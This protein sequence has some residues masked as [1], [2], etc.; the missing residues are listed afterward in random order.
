MNERLRQLGTVVA[1]IQDEALVDDA[2]RVAVR[3]RLLS[4]PLASQPRALWPRRAALGLALAS[5]ALLA[6]LLL[7]K[8]GETEIIA[9]RSG[10]A[11]PSHQVDQWIDAPDTQTL[12]IVFSDGSTVRLSPG[13]RARVRRLTQ[14][15]ASLQLERGEAEVH[16][17][18][19]EDTQWSVQAGPFTVHVIGTRFHVGWEPRREEFALEVFEGSVQ[20]SGPTG[21]RR[22]G[23]GDEEIRISLRPTAPQP[24]PHQVAEPQPPA[25]PTPPA[26]TPGAASP[27]SD[28]TSH[29][30]RWRTPT[31]Q[32]APAPSAA[33]TRP[34]SAPLELKLPPKQPQAEPQKTGAAATPAHTEEHEEEPAQKASEL[35]KPAPVPAWK[36]LADAGEYEQVLSSLSAEQVED[37]IWHGEATDLVNLGTAARRA[38]DARAGYIY[39]VVRSRFAG[40]DAAANAA[41]ILGRMQFHAGVPQSAATWLQTYLRERPNG[42]FS[43][44]AMGRLV[45]SY[46]RAGDAARAQSAARRYLA[47]YPHGPHA[48]LARSVLQ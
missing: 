20:L 41:F 25:L 8:N 22:A 29:R 5:A 24:Q 36:A 9:Y 32:P 35:P 13:A 3:R 37:A 27:R 11:L 17:H 43:R 30:P 21:V 12:P 6:I 4:A 2:R 46:V 16:V 19:E 45:E 23:R 47:R 34:P 10:N 28:A 39:S 26:P 7:Q 48:A 14:T 31:P 44:E 42:R 38:G 18:H 40:S 1:R 15:G 33:P